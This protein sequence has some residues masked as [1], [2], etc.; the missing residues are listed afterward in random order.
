MQHLNQRQFEVLRPYL[1]RAIKG[2]SAVEAFAKKFG[3]CAGTMYG[4]FRGAT[5]DVANSRMIVDEGIKILTEKNIEFPQLN[6][7]K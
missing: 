4:Y 2:K 7:I 1:K 6:K 5:P 3:V